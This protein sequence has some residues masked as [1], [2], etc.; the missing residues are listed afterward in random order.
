MGFGNEELE[1]TGLRG[2]VRRNLKQRNWGPWRDGIGERAVGLE[3]EELMARKAGGMER[4][5][6]WQGKLGDWRG[7]IGRK[8]SRG[9]SKAKLDRAAGLQKEEEAAG[10]GEEELET[11]CQGLERRRNREKWQEFIRGS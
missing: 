8:K 10:I 2:L 1:K 6:W 7:G 9:L 4:R 3:E 5:N 11:G